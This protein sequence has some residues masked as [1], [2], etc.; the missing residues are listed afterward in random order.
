M[1]SVLF[2]INTKK[3]DDQSVGGLSARRGYNINQVIG[4]DNFSNF[5]ITDVFKFRYEHYIQGYGR[6]C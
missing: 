3:K 5:I 4:S 6:S 1:Q 2:L